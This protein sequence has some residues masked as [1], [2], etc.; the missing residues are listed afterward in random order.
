MIGH[1]WVF[2]IVFSACFLAVD[3][4]ASAIGR[5]VLARLFDERD[6]RKV[7]EL[8][9][10]RAQAHTMTVDRAEGWDAAI[11]AAAEAIRRRT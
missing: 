8:G 6:A 11:I 4:A 9:L 7:E 2:I 3:L 1:E 5:T 10:T